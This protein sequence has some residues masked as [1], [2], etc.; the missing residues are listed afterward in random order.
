MTGNAKQPP[1]D[2]KKVGVSD[3]PMRTHAEIF[4]DARPR[5]LGVAYRILG[6]RA[7]AEDAVQDTFLRWQGTDIQTVGSPGAWLT[8][9]CT[10]RAID[11]LRAAYRSRVDY[12]GNWLPEPIHTLIDSE[13]RCKSSCH[14]PSRPP[15]C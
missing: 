1:G 15:S 11:M 10:R 12:V 4:E 14:P 2:H 7:E 8:A 3:G 6:S 13:R 9:V 5:L